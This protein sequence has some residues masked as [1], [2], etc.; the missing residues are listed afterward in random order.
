MSTNLRISCYKPSNILHKPSNI[1]LQT[2]E[3]LA[4][5]FEY[6]A[7]F[8]FFL[9]GSFCGDFLW[10][11][12]C[13]DLFVGIFLWGSFCG[14][15]FVGIFLWGSSIFFR[16]VYTLCFKI[17][18]QFSKQF[19]EKGVQ[20]CTFHVNVESRYNLFRNIRV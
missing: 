4:Q 17:E 12:F 3:Y 19:C 11:F 9:W 20:K 15:L 13:G 7:T 16:C 18:N 14:D 1:L 5:T 6:L 8:F 10:G 2:F